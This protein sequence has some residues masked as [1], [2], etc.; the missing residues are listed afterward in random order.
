MNWY[1]MKPGEAREEAAQAILHDSKDSYR[2][3]TGVEFR[4]SDERSRRIA[5]CCALFN[6]K[7]KATRRFKFEL[8]QSG[9]L[10]ILHKPSGVSKTIFSPL[11]FLPVLKEFDENTPGNVSTV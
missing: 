8:P 2:S 10:T 3:E 11:G 1:S 6:A 9:Y 5:F 7:K 4:F